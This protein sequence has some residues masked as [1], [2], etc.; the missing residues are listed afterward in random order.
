M[1]SHQGTDISGLIATYKPRHVITKLYQSVELG[2]NGARYSIAQANSARAS[3]CTVGGYVWLYAGIPGGQQVDSALDTARAAGIVFSERNPLWLD[4]EDYTDGTFPGL[5][6]IRDAVQHCDALGVAC[7]I[8]TGGWWWKPRTGNSTEFA[9]LPLWS[10]NY[11]NRPGLVDPGYG[12]WDLTTLAG[13]QWSGNP[14]DRS[15]FKAEYA[16]P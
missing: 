9:H 13:T 1:S 12:G 5:H 15:T 4:C 11:V 8:Y 6:V 7:G 2:G 16:S 10:S 3:G 14:V